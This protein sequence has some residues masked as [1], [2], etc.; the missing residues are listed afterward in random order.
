V[1]ISRFSK[2][3]RLGSLWLPEPQT[4]KEKEILAELL[5]VAIENELQV[6]IY[7]PHTALYVFE[8][9]TLALTSRIFY[10]RSAEPSFA[11]TLTFGEKTLCYHASSYYEYLRA[12]DEGHACDPT[13]LLLGAHGPRPKENIAIPVSLCPEDVLIGNE[14]TLRYLEIRGERNYFITPSVTVYTLE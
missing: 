14:E 5:D 6:S 3:V 12:T 9:G 7:R 2:S 10:S 11:L 1:A 4:S 13:H 8:T